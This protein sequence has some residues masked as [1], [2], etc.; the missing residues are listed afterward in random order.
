MMTITI[1]IDS[2]I[3]DLLIKSHMNTA[4]IKDPEDRYAVRAAEEN[5]DELLE[6][7]QEA[8]RTVIGICR[9]F[10]QVTD[11]DEGDD[12]FVFSGSS[13]ADLVLSFDVTARRT[14]NIADS[15]AQAIHSFMVGASLRRFYTTVAMADLAQMYAATE[16]SA[17]EEIVSLLYRKLEP[18]WEDD[19]TSQQTS[20]TTTGGD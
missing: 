6:C 20:G 13:T 15:L 3:S 7:I 16:A 9:P 8:G 2:L 12:S 10:L 14:S 17:R 18:V 11:D 5:R 1:D 19:N 4:R